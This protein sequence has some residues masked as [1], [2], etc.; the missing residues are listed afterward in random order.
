MIIGSQETDVM[1]LS[2]VLSV[3]RKIFRVGDS[4]ALSLSEGRLAA[5]GVRSACLPSSELNSHGWRLT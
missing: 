4:V 3:D 2:L 1:G 5:R